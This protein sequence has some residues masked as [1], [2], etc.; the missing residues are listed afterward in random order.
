MSNFDASFKSFDGWELREL[1]LSP[2]VRIKG[3]SYERDHEEEEEIESNEA[4][5]EA[6][7]NTGLVATF[8]FSYVFLYFIKRKL[9]REGSKGTPNIFN[10]EIKWV[11]FINAQSRIAIVVVL[12]AAVSWRNYGPPGLCC[13]LRLQGGHYRYYV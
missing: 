6:N 11:S 5:N 1:T 12:G 3:G 13:S 9:E 7:G 8:S 2:F 4:K 10:N